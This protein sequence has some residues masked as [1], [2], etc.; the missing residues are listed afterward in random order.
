MQIVKKNSTLLS[1][2]KTIALP[3][4]VWLIF[5]IIDRAAVGM[6]VI[7]T[8]ADVT[9]LL[10]NLISTFAFALALNTNLGSGRMDLSLGAQMYVGVI[11]GGNLALALGWGGWGIL[12]CSMAVGA[13]CG[14]LIGKLFIHMRILPMVLGLGMTLIFECLC[15]A[16]NNQQGVIIYGKPGVDILSNIGFI[17]AVA[18]AL[19]IV[20]TVLFQYSTYGFHLR[21]IQGSQKL[22]HDAGINIFRNCV[23]C[24]VLAGIFVACAGVFETAYK[25]NLAPVLGMSSNGSVF[26]NMFP[27]VLGMWIGSMCRS[28][29]LGVLMGSLSVRILIIGLSRLGLGNSTQNVIVYALFLGFVILNTNKHKFAYNK[30]RKARIAQAQSIRA[31]RASAVA[32]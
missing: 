10:R 12:L 8:A 21:A 3:A 4:A 11:F 20:S 17:L 25:G 29:Q 30:A 9:T 23:T 7:S 1:V 22:A 32:T 13:L 26:S 27:M 16:I 2:L 31:A 5:E 24:Y 14:L 28:Q 6:S 15:F 19:L 18:A